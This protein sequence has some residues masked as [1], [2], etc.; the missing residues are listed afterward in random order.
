LPWLLALPFL[1][2]MNLYWIVGLVVFVLLE[3]TIPLGRRWLGHVAGVVLVANLTPCSLLVGLRAPEREYDPGRTRLTP[4]NVAR[5][6]S[7]RQGCA[8][9]SPHAPFDSVA[10]RRTRVATHRSPHERRGKRRP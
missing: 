5:T 6:I 8:A 7:G 9:P 3:K 1:G 4:R 2:V 10:M